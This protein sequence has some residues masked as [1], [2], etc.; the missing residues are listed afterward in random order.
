MRTVE[1]IAKELFDCNEHLNLLGMLNT[2]I[3]YEERY[4]LF[5]ERVL[6][7]KRAETLTKELNEAIK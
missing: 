3:G 1:E 5:L 6:V 4:K 7:A 2:S